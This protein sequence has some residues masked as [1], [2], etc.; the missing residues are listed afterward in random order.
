L[1]NGEKERETM[2]KKIVE[3]IIGGA[4]GIAALYV[5]AKV[6]Y[7]AGHEMAEAEHRYDESA[8]REGPEE[9]VEEI[10]D[11][12]ASVSKPAR[13]LGK[14]GLLFELKKF[15]KKGNGSVL[16]DLLDD[17]EEHKL[18]A[19]IKEGEV[20]IDIKK[21]RSVRPA[22]KSKPFMEGGGA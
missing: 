3:T 8:R 20:H 2:F 15:M 17:P 18:E 21:R 1:K 6:A 7:E 4:I 12:L 11:E 10:P 5:V 22:I 13:K 16:G 9:G 19:Y 14:I